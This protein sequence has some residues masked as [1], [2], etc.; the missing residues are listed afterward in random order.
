MNFIA[1]SFVLQPAVTAPKGDFQSTSIVKD[2][3]LHCGLT[4]VLT[5]VGT[6]K[7]VFAKI[8]AFVSKLQ[9]GKVVLL[10]LTKPPRPKT[11]LT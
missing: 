9:I 2:S 8:I 11:N 10:A 6:C 7:F 4:E 1:P 5:N 3:P